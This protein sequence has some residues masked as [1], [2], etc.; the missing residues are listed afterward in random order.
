MPSVLGQSLVEFELIVIDDGSTDD[1]KAA[2]SE[3]SS[4]SRIRFVRIQHS[5]LAAARNRG[6][7]LAAGEFISFIDA[8]DIYL[9]DKLLKEVVH[10][11]RYPG[12]GAVY[13]G[14]RFFI[15]ERKETEYDSHLTKL[16]GDIFYFLKRSNFIHVSTVMAR[17]AAIGSMRFDE[18]LTSHEDWDFFLRLAQKGVIFRYLAED[19]TLVRVRKTSMTAVKSVMDSSRTIVGE[20]GRRMWDELK[21]EIGIKSVKGRAALFRYIKSKLRARVINFPGGKCFNQPPE[22]SDKVRT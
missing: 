6:I 3:Y 13:C 22:F 8:D 17:K 12:A 14:E 10:F 15:E 21:G 2:L 20:K 11:D 7:A 4:D 5:G 19:L 9:K 16:S 18:T 1:V